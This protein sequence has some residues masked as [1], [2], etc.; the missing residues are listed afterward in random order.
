METIRKECRHV[1]MNLVPRPVISLFL[2]SLHSKLQHM[3][4]A[5][6]HSGG[7][8]DAGGSAC[9]RGGT[10]AYKGCH[11]NKAV[12]FDWTRI[13]SKLSSTLM[14]FQKEGVM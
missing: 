1:E 8:G 3:A 14:E 9:G 10:G 5:K 11:G 13:D 4:A 2:L 7:D 12:D 6:S